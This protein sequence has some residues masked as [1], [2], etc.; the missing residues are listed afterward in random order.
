M[1]EGAS[2]MKDRATGRRAMYVVG[3]GGHRSE[4]NVCGWWMGA[5]EGGKCLW[6]EEGPP[7]DV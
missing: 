6:M 7:E 2:G 4:D 3:R 1:E 5:Q